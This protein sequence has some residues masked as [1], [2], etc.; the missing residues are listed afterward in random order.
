M[1]ARNIDMFGFL[2]PCVIDEKNRLLSGTAR[3][4]AADRLRITQ[5]PVVRVQHLSE[6]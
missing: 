3:V 1:L 5:I 6:V 2:V 4:L